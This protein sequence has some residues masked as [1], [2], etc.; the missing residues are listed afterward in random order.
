MP[1][2]TKAQLLTRE[3]NDAKLARYKEQEAKRATRIQ[4]DQDL[5]LRLWVAGIAIG[6]IAA[7]VISFDKITAE[8]ANIGLTQPWMQYLIFFVVEFLYL[9]FLLADMIMKSRGDKRFVPSL[10]A[11]VGVW[12]FAGVAVYANAVGALNF[13][14]WDLTSINTWTGLILGV[15]APLA[16]IA[17][18]KLAPSIVFAEPVDMADVKQ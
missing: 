18:G 14:D 11:N 6:F 7:G 1:R 16:I 15:S 13:N 5:V 9:M 8:A 12:F 2:P 10:I 17:I 3:Q 4:I